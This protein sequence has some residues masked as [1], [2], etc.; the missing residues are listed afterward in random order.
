MEPKKCV[1]LSQDMRK[2]HEILVGNLK[3]IILLRDLYKQQQWMF[4][5]K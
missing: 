1:A 4:K 3:E 2:V 5:K